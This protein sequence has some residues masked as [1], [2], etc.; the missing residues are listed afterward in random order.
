M[1]EHPEQPH[2]FDRVAAA[3]GRP[4]IG[5][6]RPDC[7][8]S[9]AERWVVRL[10]DGFSVFVK[11][12]TDGDT[13]AWLQNERAAVAVAGHRFAPAVVA[14]LEDGPF[15]ILVSE[16]LSGDYWPAGTGTVRWRN[17]DIAAVLRDLSELRALPADGLATLLEPPAEWDQILATDAL[18]RHGLCTPGW[19]TSNGSA[20]VAADQPTPRPE[21]LSLVHGD[22]RSDNLCIGADR[23]VRFVDWS[24]AGA[25]HPLH[26][27]VTAL[28]T[29]H[30]EG[31]PRP[32][33]VLSRPADLITRRAGG[34]VARALRDHSGPAWLKTVLRQL[35]V[36][37]LQ[38]VSDILG[39]A[40]PDGSRGAAGR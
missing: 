21:Q 25:G 14:W 7:G 2:V 20:L 8:L 17:G 3:L 34:S 18:V 28:P 19:I 33:T 24:H 16:D 10:A 22:V 29:L 13:A 35:A 26:D 37:N 11:A 31:G 4:V 1:A 30:L 32:S 40:P 15:P 38:W 39:L 12:A 23:Q 9:P 6:Q 36:I 27:L 5:W